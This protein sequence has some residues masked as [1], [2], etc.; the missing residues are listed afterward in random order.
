MLVSGR[1]GPLGGSCSCSRSVSGCISFLRA[2]L[3]GCGGWPGYIGDQEDIGAGWACRFVRSRCFFVGTCSR[4]RRGKGSGQGSDFVQIL[5]RFR[6]SFYGAP[7]WL[8]AV[9]TGP[10]ERRVVTLVGHRI[11]PTVK[12]ARP[13][14]MTLYMTG[15]ARA[16]NGEPREVGT[17]L[18]TGV[19]G[20]T[21]KMNVPKAKV[22]KLPVTVTLK[23]L[24]KGSR[25]RLRI[26]GSDAPSTM[27]RNGGLVSSRTVSV[28]LGRGVRRGLCVRVVYRTSNSATATVV[29]YKRAGFVCITLGGRI[30]LGGRAASAYGRSTG[31]PRLGLQGICSFTAA[32]PLSRVHFVLRAGHLGGTT[33]RHSFGKGCNR[34]L[35]GVLGDDGD[36]RRVLKDGAFARVLSC[37]S[38][39]YSTH[40]TKTVVPI[41]DGSKDKGRKVATALPMMICTRSGRGSRRRLVHTLALDRLATVCVGRDL[42]HLSTLYNYMITTANSDYNVACLVKNACRRVAFTMRGVVTGLA[43]V[44]YSKT[45]PDYTLGLDDNIS[46]TMFSTVLTVRRGYMSSMRNVVSGSISHDVHGLAEVN[47]RNVGRASGLMLSVVARGRYSWVCVGVERLGAG[48]AQRFVRS[49]SSF[50]S[51]SAGVSLC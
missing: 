48:R 5:A 41:V 26:L 44:V 35:N 34:R 14:T 16:L 27:T 45:G 49:I 33:T 21:V 40:V 47:S 12:Y 23:T 17:L 2:K 24:V 51:R 8:S 4:G 30:L 28:K 19:L 43:N 11:I 50:V 42:K 20:G 1:K 15:T 46:A 22:V 31:R 3:R 38:T 9:V 37:A 29:T 25:C 7:W 18:D 10:R 39:T 32:A 6:G 13:V 36:R